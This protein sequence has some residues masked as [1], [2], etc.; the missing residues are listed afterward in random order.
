MLDVDQVDTLLDLF[1]RNQWTVSGSRANRLDGLPA[2]WCLEAAFPEGPRSALSWSHRVDAAATS[3]RVEK[4]TVTIGKI[5]QRRLAANDLRMHQADFPD[6]LPR[7][8]GDLGDLLIVHPDHPGCSGA[9]IPALSALE[10]QP[11]SIP[12]TFGHAVSVDHEWLTMHEQ[13]LVSTRGLPPAF[14]LMTKGILFFPL[15]S[16]VHF[17][18]SARGESVEAYRITRPAN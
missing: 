4:R 12:G 2:I 16:F 7:M 6:R 14:H 3:L 13:V 1:K 10:A 18:D 11:V 17:V 15:T 8:L 5:N 9:A